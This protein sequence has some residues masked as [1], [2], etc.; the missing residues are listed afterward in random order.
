MNTLK[1][2]GRMWAGFVWIITGSID[3]P[4]RKRRSHG[5]Y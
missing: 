3:G 1:D 5:Y 2:K 4:L